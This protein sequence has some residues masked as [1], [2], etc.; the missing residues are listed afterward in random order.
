MQALA[1]RDSDMLVWRGAEVECVSA[2]ARLERAAALD[3]KGMALASNRLKQL[4]N[5]WHEIERSEI[6]RESALRFLR[7]TGRRIAACGG[8]HRLATSSRIAS[9]HHA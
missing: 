9:S 5:G 8:L 2:L 6:V 1:G 7:V 3:G 4:A